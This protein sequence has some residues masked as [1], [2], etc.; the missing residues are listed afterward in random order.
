MESASFKVKPL[1]AMT[2]SRQH[3]QR[4]RLAY[5][6]CLVMFVWTATSVQAQGPLPGGGGDRATQTQS[7][8]VPALALFQL[9]P[10]SSDSFNPSM[11]IRFVLHRAALVQLEVYNQFGQQV[12]TLMIGWLDAGVHEVRWNARAARRDQVSNS[13]YLVRLSVGPAVQTQQV[14][15]QR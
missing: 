15:L 7:N 9:H 13:V 5:L 4:S 2:L 6:T 14:V 12:Q 10:G 11:Q 8:E 3:L 1:C